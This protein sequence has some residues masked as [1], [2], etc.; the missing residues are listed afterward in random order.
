[1][2]SIATTQSGRIDGE[3]FHHCVDF[4]PN[5]RLANMTDPPSPFVKLEK[6]TRTYK[7]GNNAVTALD[8]V[9]LEIEPGERLA[10]LGRSGSGKSTLLNLLGGLD[11]PTAGD[12]HIDGQKLNELKSEEMADYRLGSV[13]MI[14]Q[15]FNL[16]PTKTAEQNV[17]LPFVFAGESKSARRPKANEALELVGLKDR[18]RHRPAELSGGEQQRVAVARALMNR[19]AIVFAD[20]PSGNLDSVS[21]KELH[22]L[23]FDLRKDFNQTFVIVTHNEELSNLS[24]R[25]IMMV[26]GKISS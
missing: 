21:S 13:G 2:A 17:E 11:R 23:L 1:M 20:E 16:I 10:L 8:E 12:I 19:P 15:A 22:Q 24:D 4:T 14:F 3:A 18:A 6:V 9:S 7:S 25:T 5:R 26:D